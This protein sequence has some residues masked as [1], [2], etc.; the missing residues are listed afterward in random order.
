MER[1]KGDKTLPPKS[2]CRNFWELTNTSQPFYSFQ[3]PYAATA[4]PISPRTVTTSV[5]L[6][7][8]AAKPFPQLPHI[9]DWFWQQPLPNAS[10][11]LTPHSST[12]E[13]TNPSW[14][15]EPKPKPQSER[16]PFQLKPYTISKKLIPKKHSRR[17]SQ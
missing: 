13:S 15:Y 2:T 7:L 3:P 1:W 12:S 6:Q 4:F 10:T 11:K 14:F 5:P 17:Y 8:S 16:Q 9:A